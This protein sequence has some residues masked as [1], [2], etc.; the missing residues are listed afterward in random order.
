MFVTGRLAVLV[1]LGV[2]PVILLSLAA[3]A[4]NAGAVAWAAVAGWLLLCVVAA[5]AD[6]SAAAD[7]PFAS[8][9]IRRVAPVSASRCGRRS[10]L[11]PRDDD[12]CAVCCATGGSR[13]RALNPR[14]T[15]STSRRARAARCR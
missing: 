15:A 2:V 12:A 11:R 6:A 7:P 5:I 10:P 9:A 8:S 4:G 3:N 1:G 13:R 14:V